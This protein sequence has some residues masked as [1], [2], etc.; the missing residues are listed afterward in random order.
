MGSTATATTIKCSIDGCCKSEEDVYHCTTCAIHICKHHF[1]ESCAIQ[2][3]QTMS[4]RFYDKYIHTLLQ[5][6]TTYCKD[7]NGQDVSKLFRVVTQTDKE[8]KDAKMVIGY[9]NLPPIPFD[10]NRYIGFM[11]PSGVG[12]SSIITTIQR[13][14]H[15]DHDHSSITIMPTI[16][17]PSSCK[18]NSSDI[19]IY[20]LKDKDN[21]GPWAL[22]QFVKKCYPKLI[23]MICDV[24]VHVFGNSREQATIIKNLSRLVSDIESRSINNPNKPDLLVIFNKVEGDDSDGDTCQDY[25]QSDAFLNADESVKRITNY[26]RNVCSISL[27]NIK[28]HPKTYLK[29]IYDHFSTILCDGLSSQRDGTQGWQIEKMIDIMNHNPLAIVDHFTLNQRTSGTSLYSYYLDLLEYVSQ[30]NTTVIVGKLDQIRMVVKYIVDNVI[31]PQL[32]D[33]DEETVFKTDQMILNSFKCISTIPNPNPDNNTSTIVQCGLYFLNHGDGYHKSTKTRKAFYHHDD[34]SDSDSDDDDKEQ[35]EEAIE[36]KG[37]FENDFGWDPEN[38]TL[39]LFSFHYEQLKKSKEVDQHLVEKGTDL[40]NL[41]GRLEPTFK[42]YCI[43]CKWRTPTQAREC[44]HVFCNDCNDRSDKPKSKSECTYCHKPSKWIIVDFKDSSKGFTYH[45]IETICYKEKYLDLIM[46]KTYD[47]FILGQSTNILA[48]VIIIALA[49]GHGAQK[50]IDHITNRID[51]QCGDDSKI[52]KAINEI[53]PNQ[54]LLYQLKR[55]ILFDTGSRSE[56]SH[57]LFSSF[58]Q[59]ISIFTN[60]RQLIKEEYCFSKESSSS[61]LAMMIDK[62]ILDQVKFNANHYHQFTSTSSYE[63]KGRIYHQSPPYNEAKEK[64][65][66]GF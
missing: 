39:Q 10:S 62:S 14:F 33:I 23:H 51:F 9:H 66:K 8:E 28:Q 44:G 30:A 61:S 18:P 38:Q 19:N 37:K 57:S 49:S 5:Q 32:D 15:K 36:W 50:V 20:K 65:I 29:R 35:L 26:F 60:C 4:S 55:P 24:V 27:P 34:D 40:F 13:L 6:H 17:D 2:S 25:F 46:H 11:G 1:D 3:H 7:V 58:N 43:Q 21:D 63:M 64:L 42:S 53:I 47:Y 12:K 48:T 56:Q 31:E 54:L 22:K 59:K 52:L 41:L 16:S 45:D